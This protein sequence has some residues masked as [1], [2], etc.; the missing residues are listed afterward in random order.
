M[1]K[2]ITHYPGLKIEFAFD[3]DDFVKNKKTLRITAIDKQGDR[4]VIGFKKYK[5]SLTGYKWAMKYAD[6]VINLYKENA[7]PKK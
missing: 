5:N 6:K 2:K 7:D 1:R 4:K 3:G